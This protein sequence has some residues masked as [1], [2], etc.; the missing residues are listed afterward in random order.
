LLIY[1]LGDLDEYAQEIAISKIF[2]REKLTV[3]KVSH[4]GSADQ[5]EDFYRSINAD[6]ALISVGGE[7]SYGHPTKRSLDLLDASGT[8][9]FRTDQSGDI[10]VSVESRGLE[11]KL[12][13][14]R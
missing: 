4:H 13:K 14:G 9:V 3:V 2:P 8:Q 5:S 6:I 7:N 10:S 1:A 11:V 12:E